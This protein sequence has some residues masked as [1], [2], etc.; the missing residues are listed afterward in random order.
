MYLLSNILAYDLS[1]A[2]VFGLALGCYVFDKIVFKTIR[3]FVTVMVTTV[4]V[5]GVLTYILYRIGSLELFIKGIEDFFSVYYLSVTVDTVTIY[6]VHQLLMISVLGVALMVILDKYIYCLKLNYLY[7]LGLST[8]LIIGGYLSKTMSTSKD[9]EAFMILVG[10]MIMYYLYNYYRELAMADK[11]FRPMV[12]TVLMFVLIIVAGARMLYSVDSRPLTKPLVRQTFQVSSDVAREVYEVDK[13]SYYNQASFEIQDKFE[14]DNIQVMKIKTET[15]HYLK[16]ESYEIYEEG[17]WLKEVSLSYLENDGDAI[18]K[19]DAYDPI[20]Y[21]DY[22]SVET[23]EVVIKNMNTNVLFVNNYGPSKTTFSEGVRVMFD[24][25]RGTYIADQLLE[26]GYTYSF[27]AI[28]PAYGRSEFD[29]LVRE[30]S[31]K[32]IP[33]EL[34]FYKNL[35]EEGYDEL[36]ALALEIAEGIDNKYDQALAIE[37]YLKANYVYEQDPGSVPEGLDPINYFLFESKKGFCQQF[38]SA[39]ILMARSVGIPTRYVTGFY[40]SIVEPEDY[41][42]GG[43]LQDMDL[44]SDGMTSVYDSDSHT[45]AEAYFPEVGWIMFEA[46]PGRT[47]RIDSVET[48]DFNLSE[49]YQNNG[50]NKDLAFFKPLYMYLFFGFIGL[51]VIGYS[52][53]VYRSYRHRLRDRSTNDKMMSLHRIIR[54]YHGT[55][56]MKKAANETAREYARR[57]DDYYRDWDGLN[58]MALMDDY[59]N[60]IYGENDLT[61]ERLAQHLAYKKKVRILTKRRVNIFKYYRMCFYDYVNYELERNKTE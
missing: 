61:M 46:T 33:G 27:D 48:P 4:F 36:R 59:E 1:G 18:Q 28:I 24:S 25:R 14:F 47:Y 8:L 11:S 56:L 32:T 17:M 57:I 42:D 13:M 16:A 51:M 38:S 44:L 54:Y 37:A 21:L 30:E 15:M 26:K 39:F 52:F 60:V 58:M 31:Q 34:E 19:S 7:L 2:E 12:I 35:P 45:W 53:Y 3:R 22:Y 5:L 6:V 43:Y 23:I 41:M 10:A 50:T 49:A 20:N 55:G 29:S 40:V 9:H